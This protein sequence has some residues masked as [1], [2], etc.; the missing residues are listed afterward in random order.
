M[1]Y[2][3]VVGTATPT[4]APPPFNPIEEFFKVLKKNY[5]GVRTEKLRSLQEFQ[6]KT[7]ESLREAHAR[8]RR[9]ISVT[10]GVTEAQA[11]QF[12]YGILE[13]DL[14]RRVRD[15]TLLADDTPKLAT[16]FALSERIEQKLVEEKVVTT[17]FQKDSSPSPSTPSRRQPQSSGG[18]GGGGGGSGGGRTVQAR[19]YGGAGVE[20][21]PRAV[22]SYSGQPEGSSC[23]VCGG[24]H[25]KK[26]CP[27]R[28]SAGRGGGGGAG[29]RSA[30]FT[31]GHCGWVGHGRDRCFELHPEMRLERPQVR[32]LG[33]RGA[34][35]PAGGRSATAA[36]PLSTT[37]ATMAARIEELEQ[38]IASMAVAHPRSGSGVGASTSYGGEPNDYTF[39]AGVAQ[40]EASTAVTWSVARSV[41]P[42]GTSVE[43]DPQRGDASRQVRLPQSFTL[44][45][46]F[47]TTSMVPR[48]LSDEA[49]GVEGATLRGGAT[50]AS[51][52]SVLRAATAL[53]RSPLFSA[54]EL[55][56]LGLEMGPVFRQAAILCESGGVSAASAEVGEDLVLDPPVDLGVSSSM[57]DTWQA[58]A[59]RLE[60]LPARPAIDRARVAPQVVMVDNR[61]GIFQMVSPAGQVYRPDRIL[62]DSGAQP[63]M[64]GKAACIGL[65]IRRSEIEPCPFRI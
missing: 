53:V 43:L 12:W 57:E 15:A 46:A 3:G 41:E 34:A 8:M 40:V 2:G 16:V 37:T 28:S 33:G 31:C 5:Q 18:G 27:K 47:R 19:P 14:R 51:S 9:L 32:P 4:G 35:G 49:A 50:G 1:T 36:A 55:M 45:E 23:W 26:D 61:S 20:R 21:A 65:G 10:Q 6:R 60:D 59:A 64:L 38:R 25:M 56:E 54:R 11:V 22:P 29:A 62:L 58:A 7:G 44:S 42:R 17:A 13:K 39:M 63:L 30:P 24:D 52:N 48:R